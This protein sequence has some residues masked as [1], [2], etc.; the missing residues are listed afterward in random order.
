MKTALPSITILLAL[1]LLSTH[2]EPTDNPTV[3]DPTEPEEV[4]P[5][6]NYNFGQ[7]TEFVM[8]MRTR[9]VSLQQGIEALAVK[10]EKSREA[11]QAEVRPQLEELR[12]QAVQ[13]DKQLTEIEGATLP[14][15]EVMR[16]DVETTYAALK[17]GLAK[18]NGDNSG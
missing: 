4:T 3:N 18:A 16:T 10:M 5:V 12:K 17:A 1:T 13:L 14:T 15:W 11:V 9:L 2:A 6:E 8:A 7:K